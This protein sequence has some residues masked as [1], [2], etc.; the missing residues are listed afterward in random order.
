MNEWWKEDPLARAARTLDIG[1]LEEWQRSQFEDRDR[2]LEFVGN[3]IEGLAKSESAQRWIARE[4]SAKARGGLLEIREPDD[5]LGERAVRII[6]MLVAA[7]TEDE[8]QLSEGTRDLF[9]DP[10]GRALVLGGALGAMM[11]TPYLWKYETWMQ[12]INTSVPE[13]VVSPSIL[14]AP[15]MW[16]ALSDRIVLERESG[17]EILIDDLYVRDAVEGFHVMA[18]GACGDQVHMQ[19]SGIQYGKRFP[20]DFPEGDH[21]AVGS[22]L[23]LLAFLNSPYIPKNVRRPSR[24]LRRASERKDQ[25]ELS[26]VVFVDLR[27]VASETRR[28]TGEPTEVDWK[29]RW[30]V[31]GHNRAQWYPSEQAHHVIYIAPY[32]KGPEGAPLLEHVYHVKR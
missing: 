26:D 6:T 29:H 25:A 16:W 8:D 10:Q 13:H 24:G 30:T 1:R 5:V 4:R 18:V 3:V 32:V 31:R 20:Q 2:L 9:A 15:R 7:L 19:V 21:E 27:A 14:P 12:A 17:D 28:E 23:S 11:S 22:Y